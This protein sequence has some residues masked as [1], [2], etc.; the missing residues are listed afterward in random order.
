MKQLFT[1]LSLVLLSITIYSAA[2]SNLTQNKKVMKLL[3][4]FK[5][6]SLSARNKQVSQI[7]SG[8]SLEKRVD[9][10]KVFNGRDTTIY[11]FT[12]NQ[13]GYVVLYIAYNVKNKIASFNEKG[14]YEYNQNGKITSESVIKWADTAW[15]NDS[16]DEYTYN[17]D[18]TLK[19][20]TYIT[21][22]GNQWV[23]S[24]R[25][26]NIYNSKKQITATII[27][28]WTSNAW[29][30]TTKRENTYNANN[31]VENLNFYMWKD[32]AWLLSFKTVSVFD[33]RWNNILTSTYYYSGNKI[34]ET[35]RDS[36]AYNSS[37]YLIYRDYAIIIDTIF[38]YI[39]R[40][41][42]NY[43]LKGN[44]IYQLSE[45]H[46][47]SSWS[48]SSLVTRKF[49]AN[50]LCTEI[51]A[52]SWVSNQWTD[53]VKETFAYNSKGKVTNDIYSS[54]V[55]NAWSTEYNLIYQ[56]DSSDT[57]IVNFHAANWTPGSPVGGWGFSINID[58]YWF[59]GFSVSGVNADIVYAFVTTP[60]EL[61]SFTAAVKN[62]SVLLKWQTATETNNKGFSIERKTSS[63]DWA[64]I[65]F[66]N[67][68]GTVTSIREYTFSDNDIPAGNIYYRLK[69]IDL[70]GTYKYSSEININTTAPREFSLEQNYPN[71]FNPSTV[72]SY[73]IPK[74]GNVKILIYN[75]TGQLV[76]ELANGLQTAGVHKIKLDASM[77]SSGVYFYT[78]ETNGNRLIKKMALIK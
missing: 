39:E 53:I 59:N 73:S 72:I 43:D 75:T 10:I 50:N 57:L 38:S 7:L 9:S 62:N 18:G 21:G 49:D 58:N 16:R 74:D 36:M 66:T 46:T 8:N 51:K 42:F 40:Y 47:D 67:G 29:V 12:Y 30:N 3:S 37:N 28:R 71:P 48:N 41:T 32:Q 68:A 20:T 5:N 77:L 31:D 17:D 61:T 65:G 64:S 45:F 35:D 27:E 76:K 14:I 70:D 52:S 60:V 11:K 63:S 2:D 69:Q 24:H 55:N 15:S 78:V 6:E 54:F 34:E 4:S 44:R 56:Y 13:N 1:A 25:N 23:N 22:Q 33:S 26:T 19:T